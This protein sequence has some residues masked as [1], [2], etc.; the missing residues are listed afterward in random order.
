MERRFPRYLSSPYQILMFEVDE[1]VVF[2]LF[3]VLWL[4]F[5]KLF[6]IPMFV[7]TYLYSKTKKKYPRGFFRHLLYFSGLIKIHDYPHYFER[8]FIE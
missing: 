2:L 7:G 1:L 8:R 4:S 6:I 3:F 5:G